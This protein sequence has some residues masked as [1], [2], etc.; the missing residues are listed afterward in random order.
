MYAFIDHLNFVLV[1]LEEN[2]II[3][4]FDIIRGLRDKKDGRNFARF[5]VTPSSEYYSVY[6]GSAFT[7]SSNDGKLVN[8]LFKLLSIP[9][10][11]SLLIF[12]V[13]I[14]K[15]RIYLSTHS[16]QVFVPLQTEFHFLF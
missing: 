15:H 6:R 4:Y 11:F 16:T 8:F 10:S 13:E 2:G 1:Q 14:M 9:L 3:E 5:N 7:T 12:I